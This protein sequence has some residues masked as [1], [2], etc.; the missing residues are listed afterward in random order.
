MNLYS[1]KGRSDRFLCV[2]ETSYRAV[3]LNSNV[4][5]LKNLNAPGAIWLPTTLASCNS[6]A[7][8]D[9]Y[10][11]VEEDKTLEE[12]VEYLRMLELLEG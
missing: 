1:I 12:L 8:P 9:G 11:L 10:T 2:T 5:S 7:D 3:W 4:F 6:I